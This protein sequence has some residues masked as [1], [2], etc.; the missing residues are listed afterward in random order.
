MI[1]PLR[2]ISDITDSI[3][4]LE[5]KPPK[6]ISYFLLFIIIII[7]IA[8]IWA[9][10]SKIDISIKATANVQASTASSA[11]K[12]E[13][14]GTIKEINIKSGDKVEKG[15]ILLK[16]ENKEL[17]L[18]KDHLNE[19]INKL[20]DEIKDLKTLQNAINNNSQIS[21]EDIKIEY[22]NYL[23]S[24][25][26]VEDENESTIY[27]LN[28]QLELINSTK[29]NIIIELE[30]EIDTL[31]QLNEEL[32]N[33]KIKL[34]NNSSINIEVNT[35]QT[36]DNN[37]L[38]IKEIEKQIDTNKKTI[39]SKQKQLN[40]RYNE[41]K[42]QQSSINTA[43]ELQKE[44][45]K[46]KKNQISNST[47]VDIKNSINEKELQL[48]TAKQELENINLSEEKTTITASKSGIIEIPNDLHIGDKINIDETLLS[49]SPEGPPNRVLLYINSN[50]INNINEGDK[51]K[52]TFNIGELKT[53]DGEVIQ[54]FHN[55]V[56]NEESSETLFIVEGSLKVPP[57]EKIR[58]GSIGKAS[59]IIGQKNALSLFLEKLDLVANN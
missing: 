14:P 16:I 6:F 15:D 33:E 24:I 13:I 10:Y 35:Q 18:N 48:I 57:N 4:I 1:Q 3:E 9:Y 37:P 56:V 41:L 26:L 55:P 52:Y 40:N 50:D 11:I 44:N 30:A 46:N 17:K 8:L 31:K 49:I 39:D 58:S 27:E 7:I 28:S 12:F 22:N 42:V 32:E 34:Q 51:I 2:D 53:Y 25:T 20:N 19:N 47:L 59:I 5:K 36:N 38:T 29:D 45:L 21:D 43:I 54:I 23:N